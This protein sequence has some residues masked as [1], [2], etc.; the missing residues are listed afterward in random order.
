MRYSKKNREL[1][2]TDVLGKDT[3]RKMSGFSKSI[4]FSV[5]HKVIGDEMIN[6]ILKGLKVNK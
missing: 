3:V 1:I 4:S 2:L 6:K 5:I